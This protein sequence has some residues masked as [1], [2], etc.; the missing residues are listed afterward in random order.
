MSRLAIYRRGCATIGGLF[1]LGVIGVLVAGSVMAP[2][3]FGVEDAVYQCMFLLLDDSGD[4]A[5]VGDCAHVCGSVPRVMECTRLGGSATLVIAGEDADEY[6]IALSGLHDSTLAS[7]DLV[8][9]PPEPWVTTAGRWTKSSLG[10]LALT[11]PVFVLA[12]M[13]M[14]RLNGNANVRVS[15]ESHRGVFATRME[16][17]KALGFQETTRFTSTAGSSVALWNASLHTEAVIS[18][19]ANGA[20]YVEFIDTYEDGRALF[21]HNAA[22]PPGIFVRPPAETVAW[23]PHLIDATE[24]LEVHR[25]RRLNGRIRTAPTP[26]DAIAR[27]MEASFE[28]Q[29]K[30]GYLRRRGQKLAPTF[31]GA[32]RYAALMAPPYGWIRRLYLSGGA[33]CLEHDLLNSPQSRPDLDP[34]IS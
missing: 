8:E 4:S 1:S 3:T 7:F 18:R 32:F 24:L 20:V 30:S 33:R 19:L 9:G 10:V 2:K 29:I 34:R 28:R 11:F 14:L 16:G 15:E 5:Q 23:F 25:R 21:T 6:R 12:L 13:V 26:L 17:V 27:S 22:L 31:S